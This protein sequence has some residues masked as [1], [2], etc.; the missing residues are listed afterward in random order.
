[1]S[2]RARRKLGRSGSQ[3]STDASQE[4]SSPADSPA[5]ELPVFT[6]QDDAPQRPPP[7]HSSK[8]P[9]GRPPPPHSSADPGH[10]QP[11]QTEEHTDGKSNFFDTLEWRESNQGL[12]GEDDDSDGD[13]GAVYDRSEQGTVE[14]EFAALSSERAGAKTDSSVPKVEVTENGLDGRQAGGATAD[15]LNM[16]SA[17]QAAPPSNAPNLLDMG[18]PE[19]TNFDLLSGF[20]GTAAAAPPPAASNP[21]KDTF[22]PFQNFTSTSSQAQS[23]APNKNQF[24]PFMSST[25]T[26]QQT[27]N[28]FGHFD[29]FGNSAPKSD[30]KQVNGGTQPDLMA[31]WDSTPLQTSGS[32]SNLSTGRHTPTLQPP[33][34]G[35]GSNSNIPRVYSS[36][37]FSTQPQG[38]GANNAQKSADPFGDLGK[39]L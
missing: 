32:A 8:V 5:R 27:S 2:E 23:T 37:G 1:M 35:M 17:Q 6:T 3:G 12:L 13:S 33:A 26:Q 36:P 31:G 20:G 18:G 19:P 29:P 14:D 28:D 15:L 25:T 39:L 21:P 7:P 4:S 11:Q 9:P 10:T 16:G 22:D 38:A 24:D 34:A 30:T